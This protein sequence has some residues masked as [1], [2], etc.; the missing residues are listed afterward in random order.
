MIKIIDNFFKDKDLKSIQDFVLT[1]A[2]YIPRFIDDTIEKNKENYYGNRWLL[3]ND[4]NLKK[5][6]IKQ[7]E[8]KFKIKINK[9]HEDSGIDQRN[10]D[11][12]IPH[13]DSKEGIIMN[14]LVMLSG[15]EAVTNGTVF[16]HDSVKGRVLDMHVGFRENRALL[17]PS[18][19][20]HSP[21]FSNVPNLKRY[22]ATL[23]IQDYKE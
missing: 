10:L 22:T 8:L 18:S 4:L 1:K 19:K 16:Y 14:M 20:Y 15:P 17:F 11:R 12:F 7:T 23:F 2:Y 5:L 13:H 9:V 21:H 3:K 6:F